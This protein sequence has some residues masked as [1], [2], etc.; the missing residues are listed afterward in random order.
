MIRPKPVVLAIIGGFGV[1][2]VIEGNAVRAAHL[3]V[4]LHLIETY[5]TVTLAASGSAVGLAEGARGSSRAGCLTIG[6]GRPVR[7]P[8]ARIAGSDARTFAAVPAIRRAFEQ[9]KASGG[10]VHVIGP[11]GADASDDP[12]EILSPLLRAASDAGIQRVFVHVVLGA[13]EDVRAAAASLGAASDVIRAAGNAALASVSGARYAADREHAWDRVKLAYDAMALGTPSVPADASLDDQESSGADVRPQ[14]I[15]GERIRP[16]DACIFFSTEA[17]DVRALATAF[18]L[19]AFNGFPRAYIPNLHVVTLVEADPD[20]PVE[21]AFPSSFIE[22]TLGEAIRNAGLRQLRIAETEGFAGVTDGLNGS[23]GVSPGEDR[24]IVPAPAVSRIERVPEM[25]SDAVQNRVVR[26]IA[27]G[28]YDAVVVGLAAPACV[29][30]TG[31]EQA[32]VLACEHADRAIGKIVEATLALDGVL[33]LTS[34][35]GHAEALR[36]PATG[37]V[38]LIG[39]RS[40]VPFIVVG[41]AFEGLK[42]RSGDIIGGDLALS[43]P[44]GTLADVAPTML[45]IL[46]IPVPKEMK[47]ETLV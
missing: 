17:R 1:S 29:A 40:P 10:A 34:D 37:E 22:G 31:D 11:V 41:R 44:S 14:S 19:P 43:A 35:H 6:A 8:L 38:E 12:V 27:H 42:A 5:P 45:K 33:L 24:V 18:A 3:P 4:F 30:K 13:G 23:S 21:T 26:E 32:T 46:N 25:S 2:P 20:L 16:G 7:D 39:S 9:A 36:D 28:R 47:G 15:G